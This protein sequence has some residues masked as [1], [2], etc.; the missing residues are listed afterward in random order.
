[1]YHVMKYMYPAYNKREEKKQNFTLKLK[2]AV[3]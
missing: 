2:R 3:S 1:M